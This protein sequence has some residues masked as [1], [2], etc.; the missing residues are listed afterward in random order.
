MP[1]LHAQMAYRDAQARGAL[2]GA[3]TWSDYSVL[4]QLPRRELIETAL[5]LAGQC[6]GAHD[7]AA[8]ALDRLLSEHETLVEQKIIPGPG[9]RLLD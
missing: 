1:S 5:R 7:E 4:W 8:P 9:G 6:A 2:A 3:L